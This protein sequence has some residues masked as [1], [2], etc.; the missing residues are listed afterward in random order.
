VLDYCPET[1]VFTWK[2][3]TFRTARPGAPAGRANRSGYLI[4]N[5][6][7]SAYMAH[8]LAWIHV[9]GSWPELEID[10][11]NG[12]KSDNRIENLRQVTTQENAENRRRAQVTNRSGYLGVSWRE[13]EKGWKAQISTKGKTKWLGVFETPEQAHQAYVEAKRRIHSGGTL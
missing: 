6:K 7:G 10:H 3:P 1:G 11:I 8:R 9:H 4:I 13:K 5:I 2:N 12:S